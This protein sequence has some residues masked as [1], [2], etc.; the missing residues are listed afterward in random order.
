MT[1]LIH[2]AGWTLVSFLWQGAVIGAAAAVALRLAR[3]AKLKEIEARQAG[4]KAS[5]L[6][7]RVAE[8]QAPVPPP[9][10]RELAPP[11]PPR[12]SVLPPPSAGRV[13]TVLRSH[14]Q[15][16]KHFLDT[17][18][19]VMLGLLQSDGLPAPGSYQN[20]AEPVRAVP[21]PSSQ[22]VLAPRPQVESVP[23]TAPVSV[24]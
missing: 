8:V 2:V 23:A 5:L 7:P 1:A 16:M 22:E 10:S 18:R 14:R 21:P 4:P 17:H 3:R 11:A 9:Q 24:V 15:L 6:Q 19:S 12:P 20:A 13:D